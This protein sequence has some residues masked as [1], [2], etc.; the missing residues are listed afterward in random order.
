MYQVGNGR[1]FTEGFPRDEDE[2]ST[3]K[4]DATEA[5]EKVSK[6]LR[7]IVRLG[8]R[9][10]IAAMLHEFSLHLFARQSGGVGRAETLGDLA[11][12]KNVPLE[13]VEV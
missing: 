7:C 8:R 1:G 3:N 4:Q 6:N 13:F 12:R 5:F 2:D 9:W 10:R 11:S